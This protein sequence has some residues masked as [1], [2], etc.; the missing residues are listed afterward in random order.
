MLHVCVCWSACGAQPLSG[1][2]VQCGWPLAY[3]R[4]HFVVPSGTAISDPPAAF[5]R[6]WRRPAIHADGM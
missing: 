4:M 6:T 3:R 1:S 2:C 5:L